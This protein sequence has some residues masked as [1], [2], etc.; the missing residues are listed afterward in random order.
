[1]AVLK[2]GGRIGMVG[3][4]T[5]KTYNS[6]AGPVTPSRATVPRIPHIQAEGDVDVKD[7]ENDPNTNKGND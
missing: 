3:L 7:F 5:W 2:G 1:M 6:V 4:T